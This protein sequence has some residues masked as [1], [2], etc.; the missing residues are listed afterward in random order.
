MEGIVLVGS[1][2]GVAHCDGHPTRADL[3]GDV[4]RGEVI[5]E[6][7]ITKHSDKILGLGLSVKTALECHWRCLHEA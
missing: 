7:G 5:G 4:H 6:I 2:Q 3:I 1:P